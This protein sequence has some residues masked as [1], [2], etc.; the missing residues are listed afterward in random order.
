MGS[1]DVKIVSSQKQL[2]E[3][4]KCLLTDIRA[5]EQMLENN[6]FTQSPVLFGAEQELILVDEYFKPAPLAMEVLEDLHDPDFT[7]ELARFNLEINMPPIEFSGTGLSQ[8]EEFL[9]RKF[10]R[11][12]EVIKK[13][14]LNYIIT[15][16]LPSLRKF[17]LELQN[18]TPLKRYMAL[19]TA[20]AKL[21]GS[22]HELKIKGI[23]ELNITHSSALLEASN[24]S[25]Q[26]HLQVDPS[27]FVSKYNSSQMLLA[28]VLAIS[29]NSPVL[30]GKRLWS[31]TRI[32]LF[33]Q[34]VDT[35]HSSEHIRE[36]SPRV[37][38]GNRWVQKS[39]LELYREDVA[40]FRVMLS[41]KKPENSTDL[42]KAGKIPELN[43]L[44]VHNSTVY[45]WNRPCFGISEDGKP[46]LRIENRALPAGPT[47][48]DQVANS[49]FWLGMMEAFDSHYLN[50][51][52][53]VD[54]E[55]ARAN[56]ISS[57]FRGMDN[58]LKWT[59]GKKYPVRELIK[60]ELLPIAREGLEKKNIVENDIDK[61]LGIIEERNETGQNGTTWILNSF[62]SLSN[63]DLGRE[64]VPVALAA[65]MYKF[66]QMQIPV[67]KWEIARIRDM[68]QWHPDGILVEEF[69]TTDLFTVQKNDIPELVADMMDWER[70]RY[71][72]VED[73]QGNLVG[74]ISSRILMRYFSA[75]NK[76]CKMKE[77]KVKDLMI[78]NP[79]TISPDSTVFDAMYL[80]REHNIGCLPVVKGNKLVG[81]V[82]E[83]NFLGITKTL[84]KVLEVTNS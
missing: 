78:P 66:E 13:R 49:A 11:L 3:F 42:L 4:T 33:Q 74:L 35:R 65:N 56:F 17:D 64:E 52:K 44:L 19:I 80:F 63:Q 12:T 57:A 77:K 22:S 61:Y 71:T 23:E 47:I 51:H 82:T 37:M 9:N 31:E 70:L 81:L 43:A 16:I 69:M 36:R 26:V 60:S 59:N 50:I 20:I 67:H 32:A 8:M 15:G 18:L 30:F 2:N 53:I 24:T 39:V 58:E 75:R 73:K 54:F 6:M 79:I 34:S 1:L 55:D 84:L 76:D 72:A 48:I 68:K 28:P 14:E 29:S 21:R 62:K 5:L 45:R 25:F 10:S 40:R 27:Q 38:F 46:H 83:K 7:T 41:T